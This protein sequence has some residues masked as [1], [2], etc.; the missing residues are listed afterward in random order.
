MSNRPEV[1]ILGIGGH[2]KFGSLPDWSVEKLITVPSKEAIEN[3]GIDPKDIDAGF[4]GNCAGGL[5]NRQNLTS[6]FL[7][8][9]DPA[10]AHK[11][12]TRLENACGSGSAAIF[13][14]MT[15]IMA[16]L[17]DVVIV[18]AFEK[19]RGEGEKPDMKFVGEVLGTCAHP[20]ERA[21]GGLVFPRF[22]ARLMKRYMDTYP[23]VT[24][25]HFA[26]VAVKNTVHANLN[27]LAQIYGKTLTLEQAANASDKNPYLFEG[28]PLKARDCSNVTDGSV[29]MIFVSKKFIRD[30]GKSVPITEIIGYG[31]GSDTLDISKRDLLN[32]GGIKRAIADAWKTSGLTIKDIDFAEVHDCFTVAEVLN[33]ELLGKA[34]PGKGGEYIASGATYYNAE[35][36]VNTSG[37]RI[38]LGHP[39]GATGLAMLRELVVQHHGLAKERQIKK[40]DTGLMLNFGGPMAAVYTFITRPIN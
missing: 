33:M 7:A 39:V 2:T 15:S 27:P 24:E 31:Q 32:P 35:F 22:F 8:D 4:V 28:L 25:E 29:S 36:P 18:T 26:H 21:E 40:A 14:A 12:M 11:P 5:F 23:N 13:A 38:G 17:Y 19:M 34:E 3:A 37:G 6:S 30:F 1:Y 10:L 20:K 9:T 16:G